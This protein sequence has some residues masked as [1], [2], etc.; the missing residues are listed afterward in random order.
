VTLSGKGFTEDMQA[1]ASHPGVKV[2]IAK[3]S[4]KA[5]SARLKITATGEVP[6]G[7]YDVWLKNASGE[8]ARVKVYADDISPAISQAADFKGGPVP[9]AALPAICG[10]R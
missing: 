5:T 8:S 2:Q 3:T 9:V 6:R 4:V 1:M 7:A 10:A